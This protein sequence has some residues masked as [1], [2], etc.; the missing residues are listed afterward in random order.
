MIK[1]YKINSIDRSR[2]KELVILA[3]EHKEA[4]QMDLKELLCSFANAKAKIRRKNFK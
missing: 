1:D 3:F 4:A 2:L